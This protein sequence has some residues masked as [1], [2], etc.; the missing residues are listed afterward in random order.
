MTLHP[1]FLATLFTLVF[2]SRF[3]IPEHALTLFRAQNLENVK[4]KED[5]L[6]SRIEEKLGLK[7]DL[8]TRSTTIT[9]AATTNVKSH[10]Y[11]STR[12]GI[13][14]EVARDLAVQNLG[15]LEGRRMRENGG[16]RNLNPEV[17]ILIGPN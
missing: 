1:F 9:T 14:E 8:V 16:D 6:S 7:F 3:P 13:R 12:W 4:K 17:I 11:F 15:R 5:L 10:A 2:L